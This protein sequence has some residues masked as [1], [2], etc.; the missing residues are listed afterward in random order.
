M[1]VPEPTLIATKVGGETHACSVCDVE[2]VLMRYG[3]SV[4]T[5]HVGNHLVWF[6]PRCDQ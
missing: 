6:C 5:K 3:L 1:S 4:G 2:M